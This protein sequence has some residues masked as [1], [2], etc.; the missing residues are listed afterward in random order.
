MGIFSKAET[1]VSPKQMA[2]IESFLLEGEKI[3]QA[4]TLLLDYAALTSF[5][6]LFVEKD[7]TETVV[8]SLPYHKITGVSLSKAWMSSKAVSLYASGVKHKISFLSGENAM[9]FFKAVT[10]FCM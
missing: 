6:V 8:H 5:R 7:G 2:E 1:Q 3:R 9:A 4:Y 10:E